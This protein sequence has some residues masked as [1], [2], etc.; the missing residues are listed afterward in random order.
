MGPGSVPG[1]G[2]MHSIDA[3]E[4]MCIDSLY[5]REIPAAISGKKC[6]IILA[7]SGTHV[8]D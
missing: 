5:H 7:R 6:G 4:L 3:G 2:L 8:L 1:G